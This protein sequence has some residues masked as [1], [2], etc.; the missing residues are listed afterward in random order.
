M[1]NSDNE[2][3]SRGSQKLK[4]NLQ[5]DKQS[6]KKSK[7]SKKSIKKVASSEKSSLDPQE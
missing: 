6:R 2:R 5:E 1:K 4:I 7:G 3:K